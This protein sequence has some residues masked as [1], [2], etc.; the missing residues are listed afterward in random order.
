[1]AL[2][3]RDPTLI[4]QPHVKMITYPKGLEFVSEC[5]LR[6]VFGGRSEIK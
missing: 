1:M 3:F 5:Y 6:Y 4:C 2:L